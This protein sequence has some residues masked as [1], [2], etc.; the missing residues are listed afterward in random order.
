M[1]ITEHLAETGLILVYS[2]K[3]CQNF[4]AAGHTITLQIQL[5]CQTP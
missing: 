1:L 2:T 5:S 3:Y 4:Q